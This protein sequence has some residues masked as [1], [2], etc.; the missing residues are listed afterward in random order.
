MISNWLFSLDVVHLF[1]DISDLICIS[2]FLA[3]ASIEMGKINRESTYFE[4]YRNRQ[5]VKH[6]LLHK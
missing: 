5:G 2:W 6:I 4:L 1:I 3:W